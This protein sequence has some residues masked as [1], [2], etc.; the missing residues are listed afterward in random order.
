M[1]GPL[2]A[3]IYL[4]D[5]DGVTEN[6]LLFFADDT[7]LFMSHLHNSSEAEQSLQRDLKKIENFGKKWAVT[8]KGTCSP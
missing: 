3:L 2:L 7:I 6:E 5:L 4:N 1:L 8:F